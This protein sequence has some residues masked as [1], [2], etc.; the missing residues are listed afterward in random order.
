MKNTEKG[1]LIKNKLDELI[2]YK[3]K[4][5]AENLNNFNNLKK[6]ILDLLDDNQKI[7]FNQINFYKIVQDYSTFSGNDLPF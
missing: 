2:S 4:L 1:E 6:G 5:T 7:R 3:T